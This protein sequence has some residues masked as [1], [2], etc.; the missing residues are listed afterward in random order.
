[1]GEIA[2]LLRI[3]TEQEPALLGRLADEALA[4]AEHFTGQAL[5]VR[6]VTE[7]VRADGDWHRLMATPVRSIALA[8]T[9]GNA[10]DIDAAGDGWVKLARGAA[11]LAVSYQ[12]GLATSWA[13]LPAG[14]RGGIARLAA[15]RFDARD[16]DQVPPAAVAAL[17]RPWRRMRIAASAPAP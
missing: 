16:D 17:W 4:M 7:R 2:A 1:M 9:P 10:I 6:D 12:A 11:P 8:T 14:L 13:E 15:H 5:I 3:G